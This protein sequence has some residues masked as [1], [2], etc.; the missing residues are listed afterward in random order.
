M[1]ENVTDRWPAECQK[2]GY[3]APNWEAARV[4]ARDK[5]GGILPGMMDVFGTDI[6]RSEA[7]HE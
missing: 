3:T 5:H 6:E 1:S 7:G 2:C 4:H